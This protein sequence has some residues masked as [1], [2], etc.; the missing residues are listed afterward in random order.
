MAGAVVLI[1]LTRRMSVAGTLGVAL[2]WGLVAAWLTGL[3]TS[4]VVFPAGLWLVSA[5][6]AARHRDRE[7]ALRLGLAGVA[8]A[9]GLLPWCLEL[10]R[11][12]GT[13]LYPLMAGNWRFEGGLYSVPLDG[14]GLIAL[15]GNRLWVSR[16]WILVAIG[17]VAALRPGVRLPSIQVLAALLLLVASSAAATTGLDAITIHR[18]TSPFLAAGVVFFTAAILVT[19]PPMPDAGRGAPRWKLKPLVLGAGLLLWFF[20][21]ITLPVGAWRAPFS[22]SSIFM[23]ASACRR[24]CWPGASARGSKTSTWSST[25]RPRRCCRVTRAWS[26]RPSVPS[27][28]VS[29]SR[30]SIPWTLRSPGS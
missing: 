4:N 29:M 28:F 10:W 18:L 13:P 21:P 5:L 7:Q 9:V 27:F 14:P 25:K 22:N 12:S 24:S 17:L 20:M 16:V 11:S 3:R 26:P 1:L 15:V 2:A 23:A 19:D 6:V 8:T 30:S